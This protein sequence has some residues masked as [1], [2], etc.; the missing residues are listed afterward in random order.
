MTRRLPDPLYGPDF[1]S[2]A[3]GDVAW[4]L[5]DL[6]DAGLEAPT[7][8]REAAIQSGKAHYA[9]SLPIEFQPDEAY[10]ALFHRAV[11][12]S[13]SRLAHAVGLVC[14]L[15]CAERGFDP[16]RPPVLVS[17]ARAGTPVGILMK[18]W[19][20]G[21][22]IDAPHY[23]ISIVRGRGIDAN[24]LAWIAARHDS[25]DVVFVDGWTGKGFV[26]AIINNLG[27]L[28][29]LTFQESLGVSIEKIGFLITINFG[30]QIIVD[31]IAA[32][33]VDRIGYR[34]CIV[35]A[36]IATTIGLIGMGIFPFI[37]PNPY[38]GLVIAISIN[39]IGGGLIEVLVSPIV[40]A[41]PS[42]E[43]DKAMSLLHSF[44]CFGHVAVVILSTVGFLIIGIEKWYYLPIIWT[45][46]PFINIFM[47]SI[48]PINTVVNEGEAIPIKKLFSL[49][50]FWV[51]SLLMIC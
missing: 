17:L 8:E 49:K 9:E 19:L 42:K 51:F 30:V 37:L 25:A 39:A 3:A 7:A 29:F 48:V 45:I 47:F 10:T 28:L 13:A 36:H 20:A 40:E 18:R 2:Y 38:I 14:G 16:A 12:D 24:A 46:V 31:M 32:K 33:Y 15:V 34:K 35:F 5:K 22:G 27:P 41:A 11:A 23:T 26:Q 44:Y 43:K 50:V 1:G 21:A 4:L 6:S